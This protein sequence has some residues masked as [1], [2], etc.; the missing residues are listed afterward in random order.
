MDIQYIQ[1]YLPLMLQI[2]VLLEYLKQG[3]NVTELT[4]CRSKNIH[5]SINHVEEN[6]M[7]G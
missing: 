3:K 6:R 5:L 7:A 2:Q 1:R 4:I